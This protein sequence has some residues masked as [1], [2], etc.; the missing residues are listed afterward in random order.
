MFK[1]YLKIPEAVA[2]SGES[3]TVL[4]DAHKRGELVF[5]K[6]GGSTRIEL[7]DLD[8][9]LDRKGVRVQAA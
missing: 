1:R 3:R 9:Y 5:T 2:Y 8:E 6:F 4:Y 7:K